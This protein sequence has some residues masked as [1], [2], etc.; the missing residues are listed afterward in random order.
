[1]RFTIMCLYSICTNNKTVIR[2]KIV[3]IKMEQLFSQ[4]IKQ[5]GWE[6][7]KKK[8]CIGINLL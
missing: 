1:M 2:I 6:T 7:L 8:N 3:S 4:S 5:Y